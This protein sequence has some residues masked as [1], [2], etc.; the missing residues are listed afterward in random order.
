MKV[1]SRFFWASQDLRSA[2]RQL[3]LRLHL[4]RPC[5]PQA[6]GDLGIAEMRIELGADE[7]VVVPEG[8]IALFRAPLVVAEDHHGDAPAIPCGRSSVISLI[9]MPKAP[10]PAKPTHG[11]IRAADLG[12]DDRREAVAAGP[13]QSG[14]Q[15]LPALLEGRIG[16]ADGAVVADVAGDDRLLRQRRPGWRAR[17]ARATSG[18]ARACARARSRSCPDRRPRGP[19]WRAPAAS[20]TWSVRSAPCAPRGRRRRPS[21]RAAPECSAATSLA[22]PQMPTVTGLV[23]PMRSGL[24]STWMILAFFGQ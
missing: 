22:S 23:R 7:I 9:E 13:E 4:S 16:I 1:V 19:C 2:S 3:G 20:A 11:R 14:R 12:A 8:R 6:F 21:A 15:I 10:S 24:M 5:R 17:P 18:R